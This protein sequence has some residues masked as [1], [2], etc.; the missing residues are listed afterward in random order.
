MALLIYIEVWFV[1]CRGGGRSKDHER[2]VQAGGEKSQEEKAREARRERTRKG[3]CLTVNLFKPIGAFYP[4]SLNLSATSFPDLFIVNFLPSPEMVDT[5]DC[6][7]GLGLGDLE[8]CRDTSTPNGPIWENELNYGLTLCFWLEIQQIQMFL[9]V[10]NENYKAKG[11]QVNH[12][13]N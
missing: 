5:V 1:D 11:S 10:S 8:Y 7:L 13:L 9:Q 4:N 12:D 2:R 6:W 3:V